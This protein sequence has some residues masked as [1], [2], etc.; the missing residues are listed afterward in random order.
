[1]KRLYES[2]VSWAVL[3][4]KG[5]LGLIDLAQGR[6]S[7][8][9]GSDSRNK[10]V[11]KKIISGTSLVTLPSPVKATCVKTYGLIAV[12][13]LAGCTSAQVRWDATKMRKDV[14]VYYNDQI[15]E[16][17][18]RAKEHLPFVHVDIQS[19]TS[20]GASQISGTIGA[21]ETITNTGTRQ[22]TNQTVTTDTT[23]V[24]PSHVVAGTIGVVSTLVHAAMRPLT[25]SVS[26][27]RS[28]TLTITSAPALGSQAIAASDPTPMPEMAVTRETETPGNDGKFSTTARERTL[29]PARQ[30][31]PKTIYD[32]YEKF[33]RSHLSNR[34]TPPPKGTYVPGTLKKWRTDESTEY[35]FV[36]ETNKE[37]Y[38]ELCKALFTKGQAVSLEQQ[39]EVTRAKVEAVESQ[40]ATPLAP[41]P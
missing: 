8:F 11:M 37:K 2:P 1:M 27:Q 32:L 9:Q 30:P 19:L 21:G 40:M 41:P 26:P 4:Y 3:L 31:P 6:A 14:M 5:P 17:L 16:N 29:K 38:Y 12:V 18:I 10:I 39:L 15:M 28:E 35:Y 22:Q 24:T 13:L 20:Q 36:S 23:S 34:P 33:A 25:Y 7:R